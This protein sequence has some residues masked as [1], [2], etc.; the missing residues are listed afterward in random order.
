MG[1]EKRETDAQY[2]L[3]K[4]RRRKRRRGMEA[5]M[6]LV[7]A[8][9]LGAAVEEVVSRWELEIPPHIARAVAFIASHRHAADDRVAALLGELSKQFELPPLRP[10]S[11][12]QGLDAVC[13]RL[14]LHVIEFLADMA[15]A[16]LTLGA[17]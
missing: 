4:Q 12:E 14:R 8:R 2:E 17:C 10:D 15:A 5:V 1:K 16:R 11:G 13:A 3:D 6:T 7:K 9:G